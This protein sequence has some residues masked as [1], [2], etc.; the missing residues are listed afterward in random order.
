MTSILSPSVLFCPGKMPSGTCHY[1]FTL[2]P[3]L[4]VPSPKFHSLPPPRQLLALSCKGISV[5]LDYRSLTWMVGSVPLTLR[6]RKLEYLT[7]LFVMCENL[8]LSISYVYIFAQRTCKA[9][10]HIIRHFR[11]LM[12]YNTLHCNSLQT[13]RTHI[14][15]FVIIF[16]EYSKQLISQLKADLKLCI[17]LF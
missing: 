8:R 16:E 6:L 2:C 15:E 17:I 11:C 9:F 1:W 5:R 4:S 12:R 10:R 13:F 14:L 3:S 7:S